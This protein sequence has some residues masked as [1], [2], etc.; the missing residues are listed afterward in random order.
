MTFKRQPRELASVI[1]GLTDNN[2]FDTNQFRLDFDEPKK[3]VTYNVSSREKGMPSKMANN[4]KRVPLNLRTLEG[5]LLVIRNLGYT[6]VVEKAGDTSEVYKH[7]TLTSIEAVKPAK[8]AKN[9][10][11]FRYEK[12]YLKKYVEPQVRNMKVGELLEISSQHPD[13]TSIS[14]YSLQSS[15][16]NAAGNLWGFGSV[17]T[18]MNPKNKTVEVLRLT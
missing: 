15:V 7:G 18:S 13:G 16:C 14:L 2:Q 1:A 4:T 12:G 9:K 17:T 6:Y 8:A 5:A 11:S 10:K 3:R